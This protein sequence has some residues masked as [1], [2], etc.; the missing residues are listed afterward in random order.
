MSRSNQGKGCCFWGCLTGLLLVVL[1]GGCTIY[2]AYRLVTYVTVEEPGEP[3][4]VTQPTPTEGEAL[5]ARLDSFGDAVDNNRP[6]ELVLTAT[7]LNHMIALN[8]DWA[9]FLVLDVEDDLVIASGNFPFD[10]PFLG[11]R[12]FSGSLF[13]DIEVQAGQL[14]VV[15]EDFILSDRELPDEFKEGFLQGLQDEGAI[16]ELLVES[17]LPELARK[18]ESLEVEGDRVILRN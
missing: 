6:A 5:T 13:V 14:D 1:G 7:D 17:D 8:Q 2:G 4:E 16:D 15:I 11:T 12:Y 10:F 9:G 3:V 18:I